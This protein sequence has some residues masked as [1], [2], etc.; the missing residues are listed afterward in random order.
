[1]GF[2]FVEARASFLFFLFLLGIPGHLFWALERLDLPGLL[3]FLF[4]FR[5]TCRFTQAMP[6]FW[7]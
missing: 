5:S 3:V 7:G 6:A 4:F 2:G 1:M